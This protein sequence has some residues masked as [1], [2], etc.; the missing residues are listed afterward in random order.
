MSFDERKKYRGSQKNVHFG[1]FRYSGE[2]HLVHVN[3]KYPTTAE[4]LDNADGLAVLGFFF[5]TSSN[6]GRAV[7][8]VKKKNMLTILGWYAELLMVIIS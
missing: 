6:R 2:M 8:L 1:F 3:S 5:E 4:A 7:F